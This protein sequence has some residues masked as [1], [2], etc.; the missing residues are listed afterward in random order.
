MKNGESAITTQIDVSAI[1][2]VMKYG[3]VISARPATRCGIRWA[4]FP[5]MNRPM[6]HALNS[7]DNVNSIGSIVIVPQPLLPEAQQASS[8]IGD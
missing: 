8:L 3:Q 2:L 5:Y 7:S 6:P 1:A 4:F